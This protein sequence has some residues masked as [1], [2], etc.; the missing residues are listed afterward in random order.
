[1][2]VSTSPLCAACTGCVDLNA[3]QR[4]A[5]PVAANSQSLLQCW[6]GGLCVSAPA[7][8]CLPSAGW[9]GLGARLGGSWEGSAR[10]GWGRE[11]ERPRPLL[12]GGVQGV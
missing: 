3:F 12:S 6:A 4:H 5:Q 7:W 11:A 2:T 1:M 9:L 8:R 10:S